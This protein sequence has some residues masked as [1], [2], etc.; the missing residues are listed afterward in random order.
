VEHF[1]PAFRAQRFRSIEVKGEMGP[2]TRAMD[3]VLGWSV[4]RPG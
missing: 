2:G 1:S 3:G 4:L